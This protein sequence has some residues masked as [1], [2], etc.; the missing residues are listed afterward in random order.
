VKYA[1]CQ[2][3]FIKQTFSIILIIKKYTIW[4]QKVSLF[5]VCEFLGGRRYGESILIV[6]LQTTYRK[7]DSRGPGW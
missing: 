4:S 3:N 1:N 7:T 2:A 6:V 5:S